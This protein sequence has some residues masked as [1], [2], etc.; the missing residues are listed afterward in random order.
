M[1]EGGKSPDFNLLKNGKSPD[2]CFFL[3]KI[4]HFFIIKVLILQR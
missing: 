2:F 3:P 1:C 4:L